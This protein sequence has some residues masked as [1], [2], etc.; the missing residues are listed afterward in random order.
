MWHTAARIIEKREV[1]LPDDGMLHQQMVTRR[2]EVS[3]TGKLG[4]ES[5]DK[6]KSRGLDSPDRA[7]AVMGCISCGGGVGGSW[8]RF[9]AV[10]RPTVGELMDEASRNYEEEALPSGM[11]V[12]Y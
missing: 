9:N 3:R 10:T 1:M 8:E 6:M 12:G 5:K 7:D 2:S 11:Y 4:M